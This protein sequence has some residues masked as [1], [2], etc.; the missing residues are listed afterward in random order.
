[1]HNNCPQVQQPTL[2][3]SNQLEAHSIWLDKAHTSDPS[4]GPGGRA[5]SMDD[6]EPW[7]LATYGHEHPVD[8]SA[9]SW[10]EGDPAGKAGVVEIKMVDGDDELYADE[11]DTAES[12]PPDVDDQDSRMAIDDRALDFT[13]WTTESNSTPQPEVIPQSEVTPRPEVGPS[14]SVWTN[15]ELSDNNTKRGKNSIGRP[16]QAKTKI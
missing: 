14:V 11:T 10:G 15:D 9:A 2:A 16:I 4:C 1:M 13:G 5:D 7:V 6:S 8:L 3:M 12:V